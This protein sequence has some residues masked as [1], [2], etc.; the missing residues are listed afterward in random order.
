[1]KTSA[2]ISQ[3]FSDGDNQKSYFLPQRETQRIEKKALLTSN[4]SP[5]FNFIDSRNITLTLLQTNFNINHS[6]D[7]EANTV[8]IW[9][10]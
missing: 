3:R 9:E 7:F 5:I 1:M 4:I 6:E 10:M 8:V 2:S